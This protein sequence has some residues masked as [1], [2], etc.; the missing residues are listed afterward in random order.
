MRTVLVSLALVACSPEGQVDPYAGASL[1]VSTQAPEEVAPEAPATSGTPTAED[2]SSP[3]AIVDVGIVGVDSDILVYRGTEWMTGLG[4]PAMVSGGGLAYMGMFSN[5]CEVFTDQG[6]TGQEYSV[7]TY[8]PET[9]TDGDDD[10]VVTTTT[11][12]WQTLDPDTMQTTH[13][14][15]E[16]VTDA[17]LDGERVVAI[18]DLPG[19]CGVEFNDAQQQLLEGVPCPSRDG[20]AVD[21]VNHAAWLLSGGS[22]WQVTANSVTE[23]DIDGDLLA[24]DGANRTV[25]TAFAG[26]TRVSAWR[27]DGMPRW[28]VGTAPQVRQLAFLPARNRLA[29]LQDDGVHS[30]VMFFDQLGSHRRALFSNELLTFLTVSRDG[31]EFGFQR[32]AMTDFFTDSTP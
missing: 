21:A 17:R 6:G 5:V 16:G 4:R 30:A 2:E 15:H 1:D 32:G 18:Y 20:W 22:L 12:G 28:S 19:G 31:R 9:V 14:G 29:A 8:E 25:F 26:D 13:G 23:L 3:P 10:T 27:M 24:V 7:D 11:N